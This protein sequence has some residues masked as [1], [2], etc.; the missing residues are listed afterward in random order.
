MSNVIMFRPLHNRDKDIVMSNGLTDVF[1]NVIVLAGSRLAKTEEQKRL[2]IW[3]AEKDQTAIGIGAVGFDIRNMPWNT[4][5]FKKDKAFMLKTIRYALNKKYW[6]KLDFEP[7]EK[8]LFPVLNQF[9]ELIEAFEEDDIRP[10]ELPKWL[11]ASD[12]DDPV[13][14]GFPVCPKHNV[15]LSCFGCQVCRN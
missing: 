3:L 14:N 9:A 10:D 1:I 7:N 2:I 4:E 6:D 13:H 12:K 15:L 8:I 5:T 11:E